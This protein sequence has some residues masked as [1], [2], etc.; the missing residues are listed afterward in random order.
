[1]HGAGLDSSDVINPRKAHCPASRSAGTAH[2]NLGFS[3]PQPMT[4]ADI[5]KGMSF[6]G[7]YWIER[8]RI[9]LSIQEGQARHQP[10]IGCSYQENICSNEN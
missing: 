4:F 6:P 9:R 5:A 2:Q 8:V 10:L 7:H 3:I 1:M